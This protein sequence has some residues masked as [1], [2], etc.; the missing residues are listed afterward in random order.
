MIVCVCVCFQSLKLAASSI[1]ISHLLQEDYC[2]QSKTAPGTEG[3]CPWL[4]VFVGCHLPP[5]LVCLG[6]GAPDLCGRLSGLLNLAAISNTSNSDSLQTGYSRRRKTPPKGLLSDWK[7]KIGSFISSP[8]PIPVPLSYNGTGW[9]GLGK[10]LNRNVASD[11][12]S[13]VLK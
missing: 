5:S 8:N 10:W 7:T 1:T 6:A 3:V 12:P 11:E 2:D 9:W 4:C 13:M